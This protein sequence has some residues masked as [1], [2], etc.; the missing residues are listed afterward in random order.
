MSYRT[1][2]CVTITV[3]QSQSTTY[4]HSHLQRWTASFIFKYHWH[5]ISL[6]VGNYNTKYYQSRL[7]SLETQLLFCG[8]CLQRPRKYRLFQDRSQDLGM[9]SVPKKPWTGIIHNVLS[10]HLATDLRLFGVDKWTFSTI[11]S[12]FLDAYHN[13]TAPVWPQQAGC[14]QI[15]TDLLPANSVDKLFCPITSW[16][17]INWSIFMRF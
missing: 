10:F 6:A 7:P 11:N 1:L 14:L 15:S 4:K 17:F 2:V 5:K 3:L 9:Q 13:Y 12:D 8:V 16:S